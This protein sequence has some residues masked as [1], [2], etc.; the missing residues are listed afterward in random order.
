MPQAKTSRKAD[1]K[2]GLDGTVWVNTD[3]SFPA[4]TVLDKE[5]VFPGD[6]NTRLVGTN[7]VTTTNGPKY[8]RQHVIITL[9]KATPPE[10]PAASADSSP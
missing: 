8:M 5:S 2:S 4:A 6:T 7:S 3:L 10:T 1:R 9:L